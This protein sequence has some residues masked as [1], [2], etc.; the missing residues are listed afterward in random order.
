MHISNDAIGLSVFILEHY[1]LDTTARPMAMFAQADLLSFQNKFEEALIKMDSIAI[2][3]PEHSLDDD[4]LYTKAQI[5][6]K[7]RK[8]DEMIT[9]Y[10]T[11]IE[12][13][14]EDIRADNAIFELAE[15]YEESLNEP[16]KAK[17][18]YEKLFVDY[19]GST[20][21]VEA[22]RRYRVLRGDEI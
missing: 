5:F 22:R 18:L 20:F 4:V 19:S 21:A 3:F 7:R 14:P 13:Y 9:M 12:K 16:E 17:V 15:L 11:I 2:I 6:K 8:T 1:A 10:Q